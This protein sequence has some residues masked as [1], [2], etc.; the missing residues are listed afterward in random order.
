MPINFPS[1]RMPTAYP[2]TVVP[3]FEPATDWQAFKLSKLLDNAHLT[4]YEVK[5]G[6]PLALW[7][8]LEGVPV[9]MVLSLQ[10]GYLD[11]Q[12]FGGRDHDP[13]DE[14]SPIPLPRRKRLALPET[15]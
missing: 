4:D 1:N 5:Q 2:K 9:A 7:I 13:L 8:R 10:N 11:M 12:L 15:W 14:R 6:K 3:P